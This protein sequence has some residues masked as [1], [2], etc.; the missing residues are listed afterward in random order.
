MRKLFLA[1]SV[2]SLAFWFTGCE[3]GDIASQDDLEIIKRAG[4]G[5]GYEIDD[6]NIFCPGEEIPIWVGVG[7]EE[8][9]EM[10]GTATV[11]PET[12]TVTFDFYNGWEAEDIHMECTTELID[13]GNGTEFPDLPMT[14]VRIDKKGNI[15]GGNPIP[16][17]FETKFHYDPPQGGTF[18]ESVD[19]PDG[20]EMSYCAIHVAAVN[21]EN[22]TDTDVETINALLD[23]YIDKDIC[24]QLTGGVEESMHYIEIM[25]E[26]PTIP[27]CPNPELQYECNG[28]DG[29]TLAGLYKS[30]WCLAPNINI[31]TGPYCAELFSAYDERLF[32]KLE[33]EGIDTGNAYDNVDIGSYLANA[34][35]IGVE[36]T[37]DVG[38]CN[39]FSGP[40]TFTP[41][42]Y[43]MQE[44]FW[45]LTA[46]DAVL[47]DKLNH[48]AWDWWTSEGAV[49]E[50][51]VDAMVC[52]S[53]QNGEGYV[54]GCDDLMVIV[55]IAHN[56]CGVLQQP[57]MS[58][59]P[60]PCEGGDCDSET[61]W[62]DGKEGAQ[63]P[64]N[65]WG[66]WFRFDPTCDYLSE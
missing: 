28:S 27:E 62:G 8:A 64:G 54:P 40:V 15:K 39:G 4:N 61:G 32:D 58:F 7:N 21:C 6:S 38:D 42:K 47:D 9:G 52:Y 10:I 35:V 30:G 49:N 65:N 23:E 46:S 2:I 33:S 5:N 48:G 24:I 55:F 11:D 34:F 17:Q 14:N 18:T 53:M 19:V 16:G 50:E 44:A 20:E 25:E 59:I 57:I 41:T 37:V 60:V 43:D 56:E 1:I 63:F 12:G 29:G 66:T 45:R 26:C 31:G 13:L 51:A 36:T 22:E 3:K